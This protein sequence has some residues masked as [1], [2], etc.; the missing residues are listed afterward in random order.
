MVDMV[1]GVVFMV[2]L[3]ILLEEDEVTSL[4]TPNPGVEDDD[5]S[6]GESVNVE[7]EEAEEDEDATD[8]GKEESR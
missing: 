6:D 1:S 8:L 7:E 4:G 2:S 3:L 5:N